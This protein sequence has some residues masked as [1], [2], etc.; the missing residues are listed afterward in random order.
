[1]SPGE[2]T[3]A[4]Q[5][6]ELFESRKWPTSSCSIPIACRAC[7]E[8]FFDNVSLVLHFECHLGGEISLA[9]LRG[10]DGLVF[11][12]GTSPCSSCVEQTNEACRAVLPKRNRRSTPDAIPTDID[13]VRTPVPNSVSPVIINSY[14]DLGKNGKNLRKDSKPF[15]RS[16]TSQ[17]RYRRRAPVP[18][19]RL[20]GANGERGQ[21]LN[22]KNLHLKQPEKPIGKIIVL[23]DDDD[24]DESDQ[25]DEI[26]LRL[27]L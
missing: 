7:D 1:M 15:H 20:R 16:T 21:S 26:D 18:T 22:D 24:E 11:L 9:R 17:C 27:K 12:N 14:F 4:Y 2:H 25:N 13:L 10:G 23:S 19:L 5:K 6:I 8:V 3:S